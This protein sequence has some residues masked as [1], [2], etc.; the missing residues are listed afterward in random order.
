MD[1]DSV[2]RFNAYMV[3]RARLGELGAARNALEHAGETVQALAQKQ[4]QLME[5]L[6]REALKQQQ[7]K[8]SESAP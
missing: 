2:H 7:E 6:Q 4:I 1:C 5:N 3:Q 8:S